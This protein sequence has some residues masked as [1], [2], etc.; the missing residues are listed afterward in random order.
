MDPLPAPVALADSAG[1]SYRPSKSLWPDADLAELK[2]QHRTL[3]T[4]VESIQNHILEHLKQSE[5]GLE[6]RGRQ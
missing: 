1:Q 2:K 5:D 6:E 4:S 3:Q